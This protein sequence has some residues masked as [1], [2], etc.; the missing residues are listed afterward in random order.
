M[1]LGV[2]YWDIQQR[3]RTPSGDGTALRVSGNQDSVEA[4]S[5]N[6]K[7][8]SLCSLKRHAESLQHFRRWKEDRLPNRVT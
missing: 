6:W 5:Y 8:G 2:D 7:E 1:P 4:Q 3:Q